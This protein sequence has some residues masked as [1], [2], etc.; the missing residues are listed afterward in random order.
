MLNQI[1]IL[2]TEDALEITNTFNLTILLQ[3]GSTEVT[4]EEMLN[5]ETNYANMKSSVMSFPEKTRL[6]RIHDAC[7]KREDL[8]CLFQDDG[9]LDGDVR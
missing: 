7:L 8:E 3:M 9:W 4:T 1:Y 5:I 6:V 2:I